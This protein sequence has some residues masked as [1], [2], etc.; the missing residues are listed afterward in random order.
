[1]PGCI[2]QT[3]ASST[4]RAGGGGIIGGIGTAI[5]GGQTNTQTS[6]TT[7]TQVQESTTERPTA[8]RPTTTQTRAP[9][10]QPPASSTASAPRT[11]VTRITNYDQATPEQQQEIKENREYQSTLSR[12][13]E[14]VRTI[15]IVVASVLAGLIIIWTAV[16]KWKLRSSQSFQSRLAPIDWQPDNDKDKLAPPPPMTEISDKDSIRRNMF[17][18]DGP[19]LAPPPHDFTAGAGS[20]SRS[21]SPMPGYGHTASPVPFRTD[22]PAPGSLQRYPSNGSSGRGAYDQPPYRGY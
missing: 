16:R 9:A 1:M 13:P 2:T 6:T 7:T 3:S 15:L 22:S 8:S 21:T 5:G 17:A 4:T 11:T 20:Y 10:S 19:S 14:H 18:P 12:I